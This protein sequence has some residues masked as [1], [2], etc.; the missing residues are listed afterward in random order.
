MSKPRY[1]PLQDGYNGLIKRIFDFVFSV[2]VIVLVISYPL[3]A[4]LINKQSKGPVLFK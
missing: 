1:E 4:F 3:I 2:L